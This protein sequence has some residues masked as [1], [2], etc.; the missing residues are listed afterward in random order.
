MTTS[1]KPLPI[2]DG[3]QWLRASEQF[4]IYFFAKVWQDHQGWFTVRDAAEVLPQFASSSLNNALKTLEHFDLVHPM[5]TKPGERG[6]YY[7]WNRVRYNQVKALL[8]RIDNGPIRV[9]TRKQIA[10]VRLCIEAGD[11]VSGRACGVV[12]GSDPQVSE[13]LRAAGSGFRKGLLSEGSIIQMRLPLPGQGHGYI[14]EP[15]PTGWRN[16]HALVE[17]SGLLKRWHQVSQLSEDALNKPA[18]PQSDL[19]T[20]AWLSMTMPSLPVS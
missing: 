5:G 14:Y 12:S 7:K 16:A 4:L 15:T 1:T 8:D 9:R 10:L 2:K 18:A 6:T 3:T 19:A 20:N 17:L 11:V 13:F